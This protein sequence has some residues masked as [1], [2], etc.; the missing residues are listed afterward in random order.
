MHSCLLSRKWDARISAGVAIEAVCGA[1]P[2]WEAESAALAVVPPVGEE[3]ADG[4]LRFGNFE[5]RRVLQHGTQLLGSTGFEYDIDLDE[6]AKQPPRERLRRQRLLLNEQLGLDDKERELGGMEGLV[7]PGDLEAVSRPAKRP[8]P[9]PKPPVDAPELKGLSA[10]ERNRAK[11]LA[12]LQ[13]KEGERKAR[14]V[15]ALGGGGAAAAGHTHTL[16][17]QSD[18]NRV[19]VEA[20]I[21]IDALLATADE[22]PFQARFEELCYDLFKPD[23]EI[24]HGAAVGIRGLIRAAGQDAGKDRSRGAAEQP[25]L[26]AEWLEDVSIRLVCVCALDRFGDY[27]GDQVVAPVR[28]TCAQALGAVVARMEPAAVGQVLELLLL[29][30]GNELWEVRH[31]GLL[32]IKCVA[33]AAWQGGRLQPDCARQVPA[34]RAAGPGGRA[35]PA[36]A[37]NGLRGPRGRRR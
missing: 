10:R 25:R 31:G 5:M 35:A 13:K 26:H 14:A 30:A 11:R 3:E 9:P 18:P 27:I 37:P 28:D 32:G 16:T 15:P 17:E 23:W 2:P 7:D 1:V 12:R 8:K 33:A 36:A 6:L 22:W 20:K 24:R 19:V 29:L 34:G 21:D 4:R